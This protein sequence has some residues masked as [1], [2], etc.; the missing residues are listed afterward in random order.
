MRT[1]SASSA[2]GK[3]SDKRIVRKKQM[4]IV[5]SSSP[6][7]LEKSIIAHLGIQPTLAITK[8]F[9]NGETYINILDDM[10]NK[11]VFIM[12]TAGCS[13][14]DNLMEIYL[15]ADA[16]KLMGARKIIVVMPNFPYARQ[17]RKTETGEPISA[18]LNIAL[19]K[20]SGVDSVITID[21]H[22]AAVRNFGKEINMTELSSL[23]V[24]AEYFEN[25]GF[26]KADLCVVSPDTGGVKRANNLATALKC[27]QAV[28][29]KER[30]AHN[31]AKAE[32]LS[33]DVQGKICIIYDDMI[34][35]AGTIS[36][37][38]KMVKSHGADKI[39]IAA[40]HG[41]FNGPAIERLTA[42]P[43]E[44]IVVTNSE[45]LPQTSFNKIKQVDMAEDIVKA[46]FALS[47]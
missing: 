25:K 6:S 34:D 4:R 15:K 2:T 30:I 22:S 39:Y 45:K 36:E 29:H 35:T 28:I 27:D 12:Q 10:Q 20:T 31:Q 40:S 1:Q 38:A 11:D 44:E 24:I 33:G 3:L 19:L 9:A 7:D 17:D 41:L 16:C 43:I 47:C 42:A 23:K 8:K 46:M 5:L 14:N 37:A 18:K 21:I 26:N 13:I 32:T